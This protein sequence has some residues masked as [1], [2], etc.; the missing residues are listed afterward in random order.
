ML[1][2]ECYL[3]ALHRSISVKSDFAIPASTAA[4]NRFPE[5]ERINNKAVFEVNSGLRK[6]LTMFLSS[7]KKGSSKAASIVVK[8]A[9]ISLNCAGFI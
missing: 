8:L 9:H 1:K 3:Y 6:Y 4:K 5:E 7:S 2:F